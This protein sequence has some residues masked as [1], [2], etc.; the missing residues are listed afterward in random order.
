M[1]SHKDVS[2]E[3][4]VETIY[5]GPNDVSKANDGNCVNG[6]S[7][8]VTSELKVST[9][10]VLKQLMKQNEVLMNLLSLQAS[11]TKDEPKIIPVLP[12]LNKSL[13]SF[14]GKS[15]NDDALDWLDTVNN[16]ASLHKW[17]DN[18]KIETA[19]TCLEGPAK[20][21]FIGRVFNSWSDFE[22]QFKRTFAMQSNIGSRWKTL[23]A[24][25]QNKNENVL[26]YYHEK[27]RLCRNLN[28]GIEDIKEQVMI[29]VSS[30]ELCQYLLSRDHLNEDSLLSDVINFERM[31]EYRL[32]QNNKISNKLGLDK[33]VSNPSDC[34]KVKAVKKC[35]N[36]GG[37]YHVA[38]ECRKPK[39]ETGSC[40]LCGS[41]DHKK[42][43]C[44]KRSTSTWKA[45]KAREMDKSTMS[46][47]L[48]EN[49]PVAAVQ[50]VV[51]VIFGENTE[52]KLNAI[53]DSGSGISLIK[54]NIVPLG[55]KYN[56]QFVNNFVGINN[57]KL[58]ILGVI[59]ANL[60]IGENNLTLDFHVV[61]NNT[62]VNECLL[63][64]NFLLNQT[65][66]VIFDNGEVL[67]KQKELCSE[68]QFIAIYYVNW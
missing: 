58:D 23:V 16:I 36:C 2:S 37:R 52:V 61:S 8:D 24:R 18:L 34:N 44:P 28:L 67:I 39:R 10:Y 46:T 60:I 4:E 31:K 38:E 63:G 35:T 56:S 50:K 3:G 68:N 47:M 29:G 55:V 9:D 40:F 6:G 25:V 5:V 66:T 14:T 53:L 13:P 42:P 20:Q 64:R 7:S 41:M 48:V 32:Q 49:V 19:R 59:K 54:E 45:N 30:K 15:N 65:I 17:P 12:D 43:D 27:V 26:D 22:T 33:E 57:V 62:M 11:N 1:D 21:W 51:G